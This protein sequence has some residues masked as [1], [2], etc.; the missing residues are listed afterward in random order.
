[1]TAKEILECALSLI[2]D[3]K[4]W[5]RGAVARDASGH[6]V[7]PK[8]PRAQRWCAIGAFQ[9]CCSPVPGPLGEASKARGALSVALGLPKGGLAE[10]N[11]KAIKHGGVG[12]KG[13]V[14]GFRKAIASCQ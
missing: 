6:E 2:E 3:P 7:H 1:M 5:T 13:I 10:A 8:N 12:H 11:D 4:H 14:E 9:A